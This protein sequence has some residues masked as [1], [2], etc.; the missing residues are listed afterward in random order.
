[1]RTVQR[2]EVVECGCGRHSCEVSCGGT[3][4]GYGLSQDMDWCK[5]CRSWY[6]CSMGKTGRQG[7]YA[8][9]TAE[10]ISI[11]KFEIRNAS[12]FLS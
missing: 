8:S 9:S 6:Q 4:V 7:G 12:G 5:G 11:D 2:L 3:A 1:V 10:H